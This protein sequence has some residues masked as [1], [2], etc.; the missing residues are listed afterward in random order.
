[1]NKGFTL[2]EL[3]VVMSI[4][5]ILVSIVG[6]GFR[7]SQARGR[8]AQRKSDLKAVSSAV[9]IYYSDYGKYP[10]DSLISWGQEF[11]DAKTV[12]IKKLPEDPVSAQS[13]YYRTLDSNQ[14]FQLFTKL[15]NS[16]DKDLITTS[17][18]NCGG[19]CNFAVI[20]SNTTPD[21]Q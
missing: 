4:I 11:S 15:E 18:N 17:Y 5:G 10:D 1:M 19:T 12:F 9:E 21:E 20:S 8:D 7:S 14:K 3:L 2:V 16:Q 13:Y 6:G